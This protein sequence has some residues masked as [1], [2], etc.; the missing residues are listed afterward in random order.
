MNKTTHINHKANADGTRNV[1]FYEGLGVGWVPAGKLAPEVTNHVP[2][3]PTNQWKQRLIDEA[4]AKAASNAR[5]D[6]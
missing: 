6:A 4:R 1:S 5:P 3:Q 2:N